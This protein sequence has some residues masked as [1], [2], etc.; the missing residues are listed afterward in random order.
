MAEELIEIILQAID[1]AS[2]VFSS[3]SSSAE[4]IGPAAESAGA[5]ASGAFD[6]VES[7]AS[8]ASG[9][10]QDVIDYC[11]GIDGTP[12]EDAASSAD[13]LEQ[14][15]QE[16]AD[17][18]SE[19]NNSAGDVMAAETLMGISSGV[20]DSMMSMVAASGNFSDSMARATM[21]AEGFGIS[22]DQMK[23]TINEISETTGRAG[24][25]IRESFIK[26]TAR[27]VTDM[28]S[29]KTMMEGAGAQATLF[30]TDIESMANKF[31]N[32]AMRSTLMER[33]LAET[34][35]TMGELA[36]AM[37]MTG[38]T[39]DEVKAKWQELDTNQ[40]AA[41]LGTAASMNEGKTANDAY[42][43]SWAGM[44]EQL[45]VAMS[46]LQRLVGDVLAPTVIPALQL[47]TGAMQALGNVI[48][49]AMSSP[50]G[51]L[52]SLLGTL[53]GAFI[54]AVTGVGALR[55]I[56]GFFR[57]EATLAAIQT[58]ALAI[59][60]EMQAGASI[61]SAAANVIG[62]SGFMGLATAAWGAATAV[63][64][65]LAPL[66][67]FIAIGAAIVL[68]IYEI[69]K[70]F[71][72]WHD[73]GSMMEAIAAG[74]TRLWNAFINHP[75]VQAMISAISNALSTLWG[76]IQ[77]AGAAIAE[78]FGISTGGEWDI[79]STMIHNVGTSWEIL[80]GIVMTV[81]TTFQQLMSGQMSLLDVIVNVGT[82]LWNIWF[83]LSS[84]LTMLVL[85]L[86]A[87]LLTWAIQGGL[88]FL[89]GITTYLSQVPMRVATFLAQV[90]SR[91]I[92]YGARWVAQGRAKASQLLNGIVSF[93]RQLPGRA[94]SALL[95]VVTAI[96]SA[97]AQWVSNAKNKAKA[98]VDGVRNTLS[99]TASA[100][101]GALSAVKDAVVKPF[102]DAYN[103]AKQWWDKI[104]N[105]GNNAA[106]FDFTWTPPSAAGFELGDVNVGAG[107]VST[108]SSNVQKLEV[109]ANL[110]H[111]FRYLPNGVTAEEVAR[112]VQD[113]TTDDS[114]VKKLANNIT[115]QREDSKVKAV[116]TAKNNRARGI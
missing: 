109:E 30:G 67:P 63:W 3:V 54:I 73:A 53:G 62:A 26:A 34:G 104:A 4:E 86:I 107:N 81:V 52:I 94:L 96:V 58:T 21:E 71:G 50:L 68:V 84:Q 5:E 115:F 9:S 101:T 102:Q 72:W 95:G 57:V 33:S 105:L 23:S 39:A 99:N 44:Q 87:N 108:S 41:I 27:G 116:L 112:I 20:A 110:T 14:E 76:Y 65:V 103:Q 12:M 36:T 88:N 1:N 106:G 98:V 25:Q 113:S 114:F 31:S 46:K 85:T 28:G 91:I 69:G 19:L 82:T 16:A 6:E 79:V 83:T 100:V 35:I 18:M 13:N 74:A 60:E 77:Q 2:E 42:K 64:A 49:G 38:A 56:L 59:A 17:A 111:D 66:L 55:S 8:Q 11:Q 43:H 29:F 61:T 93:L 10:I 22:A 92:S 75:D 47:A 37:G 80:K 90:L 89:T 70:A 97:G 24:G 78:F 32:M 51:G 40:R 45:D 15:V 48:S 7:S